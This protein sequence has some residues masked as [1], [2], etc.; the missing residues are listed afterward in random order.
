M[1]G[2]GRERSATEMMHYKNQFNT[3]I[4]LVKITFFGQSM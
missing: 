1:G 4:L 2:G 3:E